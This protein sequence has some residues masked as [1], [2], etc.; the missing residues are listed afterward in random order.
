MAQYIKP[1][2]MDVFLKCTDDTKPKFEVNEWVE[3]DRLYKL[4][5]MTA[6]VALNQSEDRSLVI[7]DL[8]GKSVTPNETVLGLKESRFV[9]HMRI[10][11]N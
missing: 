8:D 6:G 2:A 11:L 7:E 9:E 10:Y 4:K 1:M 3:R 5:F